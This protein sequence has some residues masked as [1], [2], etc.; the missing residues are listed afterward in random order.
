MSFPDD[1][2]DILPLLPGTGVTKRLPVFGHIVFV[3]IKKLQDGT[4]RLIVFDQYE[5]KTRKRFGVEGLAAEDEVE[6]AWREFLD[7]RKSIFTHG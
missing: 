7:E 2:S 1:L 6:T 4:Y 5:G 3:E